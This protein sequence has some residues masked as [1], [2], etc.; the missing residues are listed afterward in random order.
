[1]A[2]RFF[3][4]TFLG[5]EKNKGVFQL[6]LTKFFELLDLISILQLILASSLLFIFGFFI[7]RFSGKKSVGQDTMTQ[8]VVAIT[9]GSVLANPLGENKTVLGTIICVATFIVW[10]MFFEWLALKNSKSEKLIESEPVTLIKDG[11]LQV[12]TLRRIRMTVDNLESLLR[13]KGIANIDDLRTCSLEVNGQIG[14]EYKKEK[15]P[16]T[17]D[18]FVQLMNAQQKAQQMNQQNKASNQNNQNLFDEVRNDIDKQNNTTE[19]D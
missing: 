2:F 19:L 12:D 18:D 1:L 8:F 15:Q 4:K 9:I 6:D 3:R 13:Q 10:M 7:I 11:R 5:L 17:Y 14:Y 16:L